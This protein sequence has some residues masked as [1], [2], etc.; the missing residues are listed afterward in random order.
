MLL[1]SIN[2]KFDIIILSETWLGRDV[3][4]FNIKGYTCYNYYSSLN[5]SNDGISIYIK[6]TIIVNDV[7]IEG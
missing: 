3:G 6:Y 1:S 4:N 7:I 2:I 5:I